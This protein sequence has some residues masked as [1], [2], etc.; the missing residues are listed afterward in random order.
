MVAL[1][2][3]KYY[4]LLFLSSPHIRRLTRFT[5]QIHGRV[6]L[7]EILFSIFPHSRCLTRFT[8]Q[9]HG[10][11]DL[12]EILSSFLSFLSPQP[13]PDTVHTASIQGRG[14]ILF[15]PF[16][17]P[18]PLPDTIHAAGTGRVDLGEMYSWL[19]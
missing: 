14:E 5:L 13:P 18:Q 2:S 9:V 7:R 4:F 15:L 17:S 12:E 16:L 3:E 6:D 10:Q 11:V 8:L 19:R 1:T